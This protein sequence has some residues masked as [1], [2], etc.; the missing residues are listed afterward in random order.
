MPLKIA[1][2]V[3]SR[4]ERVF[5]P[6]SVKDKWL[7]DNCTEIAYL[8][9]TISAIGIISNPLANRN[10]INGGHGSAVSLPR[11]IVGKRHCRVES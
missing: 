8:E 6:E 3:Y 1:S 9:F 10:D 11:F 7:L 2:A 5:R 4:I